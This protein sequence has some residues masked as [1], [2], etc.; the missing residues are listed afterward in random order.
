LRSVEVD[1]WH[2]LPM[3][4]KCEDVANCQLARLDFQPIFSSLEQISTFL[5]NLALTLYAVGLDCDDFYTTKYIDNL[6]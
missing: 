3:C 5:V 1:Y 4:K 6:S 2:A